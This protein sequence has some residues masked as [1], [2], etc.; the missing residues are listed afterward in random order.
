M[1][2]LLNKITLNLSHTLFITLFISLFII[3]LTNVSF[4]DESRKNN[5]AYKPDAK[6]IEYNE[7]G[8]A[9][10]NKDPK[11]AEELFRKALNIDNKNISALLNYATLKIGQKKGSEV[12]SILQAYSKTYP[13]IADIHYLLGDIYFAEKQIDKALESYK[14]V[15][16]LNPNEKDLFVK[17]GN[18]YLLQKNLN[19]AEFMYEQ[20]YKNTPKN[21]ALLNN[22]AN[23]LLANHN[24]KD[25]IK[26]AKESLSIKETKEGFITLATAYEL[27]S[28]IPAALENYKKAKKLKS[29]QEGLDEKIKDLQNSLVSF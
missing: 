22:Y 3:F 4:A 26:I 2:R 15:L 23:V 18:I 8:V 24:I 19:N 29:S 11:A 1:K 6:S 10:V 27:Q 5:N 12:L 21:V 13:K 9:L 25:A 17:L 7:K 16:V 28:D 20:A 14:K